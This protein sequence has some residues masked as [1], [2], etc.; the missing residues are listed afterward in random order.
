MP[1]IAEQLTQLISDRDDLVSNLTTKGI[2][3]LIGDE[4]FTEL[5]PEVLN[6]PSGGGGDIDWSAIGY[7]EEP[8]TG[9]EDG[10]EYAIEIKNNWRPATSLLNKFFSDT[11]LKFMPLVDTS[12][13]TDMQ[14]MFRNCYVLNTIPQLNTSNVTNMY[15][16]FYNDYNLKN[17]PL[18]DTEKVTNMNSMFFNCVSLQKILSLDTSNVTNMNAMFGGCEN[19]INVPQFNTSNVTNI[20]SMF[21]GCYSLNNISLDNILQMCINAVSYTGTKTLK[22]LGFQYQMTTTYPASRIEALPHYQ[23]FLDAGWTIGY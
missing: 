8:D 16:M 7:S 19:L 23:D 2:S 21:S 3:G 11:K 1:T 18:L 10:Y 14:A 20:A 15:Q 6:I 22:I 17:M 13:A 5:V 12:T 4:T 9:I